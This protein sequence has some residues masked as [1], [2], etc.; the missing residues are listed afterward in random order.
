MCSSGII[1]EILNLVFTETH[2]YREHE[3]TIVETERT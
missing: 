3:E 1:D 2:F